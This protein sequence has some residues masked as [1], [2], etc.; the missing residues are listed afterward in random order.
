VKQGDWEEMR[1]S[2]VGHGVHLGDI[3][4]NEKLV[5]VVKEEAK[6][7]VTYIGN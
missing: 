6:I 7:V 3:P 4:E 5:Y 2:T 1:N